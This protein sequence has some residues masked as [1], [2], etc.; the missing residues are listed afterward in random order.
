MP[1]RP[2]RKRYITKLKNAFDFSKAE[3]RGI[4]VLCVILL[5]LFFFSFFLSRYRSGTL[6]FIS[7]EN[8]A[9]DSF[10]VQQ[11]RYIDSINALYASGHFYEKNRKKQVFNPFDFCPDTM[12]INDW[13]RLGF[14]DKQASQIVNYQSKGGKFYQKEDLKKLYCVSEE[15]YQLLEP[16]IYISSSKKEYEKR[17]TPDLALKYMPRLELNEADSADLLLI[18]GIGATTASV[19]ISYRTKLGGFIHIDQLKEIKY[20]DDERFAKIEPHL[21]VNP[22]NIKKINVNEADFVVLVKHPYIDNYLAKTIVNLRDKKGKYASLEEMKKALLIYDELY[23]K[24]VPYL[25]VE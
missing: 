18:S 17:E 11:Q 24:I 25:T 23:Q 8:A 15:T 12:K 14:S 6:S 10:L 9:I 22:A 4:I 21:Y 2:L 20:I 16:H 3:Q 7:T 5:L 19:I 1:K 13:M